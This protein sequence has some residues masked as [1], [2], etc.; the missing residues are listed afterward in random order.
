MS[1]ITTE[2]ETIM[3]DLILD[4]IIKSSEEDKIA[5]KKGNLAYSEGFRSLLKDF[6]L[7]HKKETLEHLM[8]ISEGETLKLLKNFEKNYKD[9]LR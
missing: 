9:M 5:I 3:K 8:K 4:V 2:K 1:I 7:T 6:M